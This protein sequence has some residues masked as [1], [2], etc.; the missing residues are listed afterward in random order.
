[1]YK[2]SIPVMLSDRFKKE[3]TLLELKR[4]KADRVFLAISTISFN[5]E[6]RERALRL[7]AE[8]IPYF[9][10]NGIETGVWFWTFLRS[11]KEDNFR[12]CAVQ[13]DDT[14][15][16]ING[17]YCPACKNL[18]EDTA[19]F[20]KEVAKLNPDLLQF[21]DDFR[22]PSFDSSVACFCDKHMA[23]YCEALGEDIT[24]EE[25]YK[26]GFETE[27]R[28]KYRDA[29]MSVNGKAMEN[30]ALKMREAV[31]SINPE[32]RFS[33]CSCMPT[34]DYNG[35]DVIKL[36]KLLAGKTKPI[37]RLIGAP[38]WDEGKNTNYHIEASR[39]ECSWCD[40]ENV[41]IMSEGDTYPRPRY[42]VPANVLE[43]F[44]TALR[45]SGETDGSLKY[46]LDYASSP[47][48]ETGY[49]DRHVK[50]MGDYEKI[51]S[52]FDTMKSTGV[53]VYETLHKFADSDL[54][55]KGRAEK[56][57]WN[58]FFSTAAKMLTDLSIPTTYRGHGI[59]GIVFG[60]NAR[61]LPSEAIENGLILDITAAKILAEK[62]IDVGIESIG[63]R[64]YY[65]TFYYPRDDEYTVSGY[66]DN[67]PV[68][69]VEFKETAEVLAYTKTKTTPDSET[70]WEGRAVKT[71]DKLY[72][73]TI[74]YTNSKGQKFIV[75]AFE[76]WRTS[77][78]H[79]KTYVMQNLLLEC[80]SWLSDGGL[81]AVCKG[82]P[83]LYIQCKENEIS[84]AIG[85]WNFFA[86][87]I[88]NPTIQLAN[89]F[90]RAEFVNCSGELNGNN[91]ILSEMLPY[92]YAFVKLFK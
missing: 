92:S 7:L 19:E 58:T 35:T 63:K 20:I 65:D 79:W 12:N 54:S 69:E 43:G 17:A 60:E 38:Y 91:L 76:G 26:K 50:H 81:P 72:P 52:M 83:G 61:E 15:N 41:E 21:D 56:Y 42:K 18:I 82:N 74:K 59:C 47:N 55:D 44:D 68:Y 11:D 39:L 31:D 22:I 73:D 28:N 6:K 78:N 23:L 29:V 2:I 24:A 27:K 80:V 70:D 25:L 87:E 32:I 90:S 75:F 45:F 86:D 64:C 46:M 88:D 30:F 34:W 71:D 1:M 9:K 57:G 36:A 62:G 14:G 67:M 49:I 53:R 77:P 48:Y 89:N 37:I 13:K 85:L 3:E 4:A 10:S 33:L 16:V 40:G 8:N 66:H 51:H 5:K 84:Q